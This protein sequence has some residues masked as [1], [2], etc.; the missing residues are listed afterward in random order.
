MSVVDSHPPFEFANDKDVTRMDRTYTRQNILRQYW[1]T[2]RGREVIFRQKISIWTSEDA[3][4][5]HIGMK[6]P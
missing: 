2:G 1:T 3:T 5:P 6:I 4:N